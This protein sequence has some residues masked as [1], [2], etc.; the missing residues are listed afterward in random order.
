M[1]TTGRTTNT[2]KK[3][4]AKKPAKKATA[5][6]P[7]AKRTPRKTTALALVKPAKA[8]LPTRTRPFMTDIQGYATLAA[9]IA[10]ITTPRIRDWADGHD[11]TAAR[12][13]PDHSL[14][15]YT[16]NTHTLTWQALCPMGA[17]HTYTLT[18]PSTAAA[19]RVHATR[20]RTPHCDLSTVP[21]L[22]ADELAA[23]GIHTAAT[24]PALPGDA[25]TESI[26]VALP[27]REPRAL[28][29]ALTRAKTAM[30]DTQPL[31]AQDI[32]DGLAA[33]ATDTPK[34]HP[35]P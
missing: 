13:L 4:T 27:N 22:T 21:P 34:E 15:T 7:P 24:A 12:L 16:Q 25:P 26:P 31:P 20:C 29:D 32:A 18:S 6:K 9:R 1:A 19:A 5:A 8:P 33:R 17:I 28:G 10:G 2:A 30:A 14:L 35:E 23:L 3:T 11:G